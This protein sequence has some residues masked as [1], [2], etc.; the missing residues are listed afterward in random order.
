MI[1]GKATGELCRFNT[2]GKQWFCH[3]IE[4]FSCAECVDLIK[5]KEVKGNG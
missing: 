3:H 4:G 2:E 5:G 1:K